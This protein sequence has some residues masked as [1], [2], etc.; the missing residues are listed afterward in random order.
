M[1]LENRH[2]KAKRIFGEVV[3]ATLK[4]GYLF[5]DDITREILLKKD[6]VEV[7][8]EIKNDNGEIATRATEKGLAEAKSQTTS[9]EVNTSSV[10]SGAKPKEEKTMFEIEAK[11]NDFELPKAKKGGST[12]GAAKYPFAEMDVDTSF[13]VPNSACKTKEAV[14]TMINACAKANKAF[15]K[16]AVNADGTAK[17]RTTRT[18]QTQA[19]EFVRVYK[20]GPYTKDG[21][22]GAMVVR[23]K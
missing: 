3:A 11:P 5:V 18:G 20:A 16:P 15:G 7:N 22:E 8:P 19:T 21:V 4:G 6:L 2:Q 12:A 14:K 10:D 13:F 1:A 17:M 9:N 23:V